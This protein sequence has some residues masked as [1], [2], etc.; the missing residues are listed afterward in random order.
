M[1]PKGP[2]GA[3]LLENHYLYQRHA[4]FGVKAS[5]KDRG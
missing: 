1:G 3:K 4:Y 5:G 2:T